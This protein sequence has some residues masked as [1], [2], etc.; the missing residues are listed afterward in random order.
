MGLQ[1]EMCNVQSKQMSNSNFQIGRLCK[2]ITDNYLLSFSLSVSGFVQ[3]GCLI[4][5]KLYTVVFKP[6]ENTKVKVMKP[7][8]SRATFTVPETPPNS[9]AVG[10]ADGAL[11]GPYQHMV[12]TPKEA[13]CINHK[14]QGL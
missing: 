10:L 2:L 1:C 3:L 6:D 14:L 5:P 13:A 4:F 11:L 12:T 9:V 8:R 7:H